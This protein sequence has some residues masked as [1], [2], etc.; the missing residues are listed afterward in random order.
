MNYGPVKRVIGHILREARYLFQHSQSKHLTPNTA[1]KGRPSRRPKHRPRGKIMLPAD[2]GISIR[3]LELPTHLMARHI[4]FNG[5]HF[6]QAI[7]CE[8]M[9][10]LHLVHHVSTVPCKNGSGGMCEAEGRQ[11]LID[12]LMWKLAHRWGTLSQERGNNGWHMSNSF[13]TH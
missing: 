8:T 2:S 5:I 3:E 4:W 6:I 11:S 13:K 12:P 1:W 10:N 7:S 9:L